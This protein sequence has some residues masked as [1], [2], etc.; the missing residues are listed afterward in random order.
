MQATFRAATWNLKR[1]SSEDANFEARLRSIGAFV[2]QVLKRPDILAIQELRGPAVPNELHVPADPCP[3]ESIATF[4]R[5]RESLGY[6]LENC[7]L[8]RAGNIGIR[9]A[10]LSNLPLRRAGQQADV[11]IFEKIPLE[12]L[13]QHPRVHVDSDDQRLCV[14]EELSF[15]LSRSGHSPAP[16]RFLWPKF[17]RP[18]LFAS[19]QLSSG[20]PVNVICLH[21]KSKKARLDFDELLPSR[22]RRQSSSDPDEIARGSVRSLV[23]RAQEAVAARVLV[24]Q[25]LRERPGEAMLVLGDLND[26]LEAE[27]TRIIEGGSPLL[28]RD[29]LVT[30]ENPL[31]LFN[32]TRLVN[33][34]QRWTYLHRNRRAQFDHIFANWELAQSLARSDPTDLRG[35]IQIFNSYLED[36]EGFLPF[37]DH[38][39]VLAAFDIH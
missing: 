27:T 14:D 32:L 26:D 20:S 1:L 25:L 16:A 11:R 4:D 23:A 22:R 33:P 5:L 9:V 6:P 7:C 39:P 2:N 28:S 12:S 15:H 36:S 8:G 35:D 37:S 13:I 34:E 3:E 18:P 38:A 31:R 21:L 24:T 17:S 30:Q 29:N 19:F 10:L